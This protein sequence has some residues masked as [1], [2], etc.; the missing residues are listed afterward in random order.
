MKMSEKY[1]HK[2][3]NVLAYI[4]Q[5]NTLIIDFDGIGISFITDDIS[6]ATVKVK[7]IGKIGTKNFKC[8]LAR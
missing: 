3:C 4:K 6:D 8:E 1:K 5:I 7:Y 2:Q